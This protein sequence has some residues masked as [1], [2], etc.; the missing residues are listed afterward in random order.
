MGK[1]SRRKGS[2]KSLLQKKFTRFLCVRTVRLDLR[3]TSP[4]FARFFAT[5]DDKSKKSSTVGNFLA[6]INPVK[7]RNTAPKDELKENESSEIELTDE[8]KDFVKATNKLLLT[9][10]DPKITKQMLESV[11]I[12]PRYYD[13]VEGKNEEDP[14]KKKEKRKIL[15]PEDQKP[16]SAKK[17]DDEED[18]EKEE[19]PTVDVTVLEPSA[20]HKATVLFLAGLGDDTSYW[21]QVFANERIDHLLPSVKFVFLNPMMRPFGRGR[22]ETPSWYSFDM[23]E[24]E[25]PHDGIDGARLIVDSTAAEEVSSVPSEKIVLAGFSQGGAVALYSALTSSTKFG[26][27][28]SIGGYLPED[29]K[30]E[31]D[32]KEM[33]VQLLHSE[34]DNF[35]PVRLARRAQEELKKKG[36]TDTSV[37]IYENGSHELTQQGFVD[38]VDWIGVNFADMSKEDI[39]KRRE[40]VAASISDRKKY[41][42][43]E[44]LLAP[45]PAMTRAQLEARAR[46]NREEFEKMRADPEFDILDFSVDQ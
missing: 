42:D 24:P 17:S 2:M 7:S 14:S 16:I 35:I 34:K 37:Q 22:R 32:R 40:E 19:E 39:H 29:D 5:D 1:K 10:T 43:W 30:L 44:S 18:E 25:E 6:R 23:M 9:N 20:E 28:V 36:I 45:K 31:V 41:K 21:A 13:L 11:N 33:K 27:A 26:G 12:D 15:I 8:P 3:T 4:S 38:L 46:A